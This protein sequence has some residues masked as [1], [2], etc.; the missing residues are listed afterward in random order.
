MNNITEEIKKNLDYLKLPYLHNNICELAEKAAKKNLSHLEF[1]TD[2]ISMEVAEKNTR[3]VERRIKQAAFPFIK[4]LE[5][6][7]WS[8]PS[9]INRDLVKHLFT[10]N[11]I[12]KKRNIAFVSLPGLGKTHLSIALAHHACING[13]RVRFETANTIIEK[14]DAAQK[15]GTFFKTMKTYTSLCWSLMKLDFFP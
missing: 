14:L 5:G 1:F 12:E 9:K 7:Q 6:F 4:T 10:L 15:N 8:H 3:A 11:F 2:A 13:Y